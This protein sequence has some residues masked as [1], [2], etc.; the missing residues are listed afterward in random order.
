MLRS[1]GAEDSPALGFEQQ[2]AMGDYAM[3]NDGLT[4]V[5][6][7]FG[8]KET[9]DRLEAE[10]K[11]K[12]L[13]VFARVDHAAGAA[14]VGMQLRPTELLIFGNARGGTPL[15]QASQVTGIDLP[16]KA[17]VYEDASGNAWLA[18][19]DPSWIAHRHRL[20]TGVAATVQTLTRALEA[21]AA[22]AVKS[23]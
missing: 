13:T 11:A 2:V 7:N 12:G 20:G 4:T 15:M 8:A 6:S 18:Y 23:P 21:F 3:A 5:Q 16:L 9:M 10:V 22:H 17:L 14:A 19:D 1:D